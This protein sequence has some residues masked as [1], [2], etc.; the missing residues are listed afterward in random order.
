M[1]SNLRGEFGKLS[2]SISWERPDFSDAKVD[3]TI[4]AASV[5]TRDAERDGNLRG[6]DFFDVKKFPSLTFKSKRVAKAKAKGHLLL[7]GD[8][9]IH[10]VTKEVAFDV[11]GP[12]AEQKT[13][14]G[15]VAIAAE[16]KATINR[17][18]FGLTWNQALET[19]GV[20]VGDEVRIDIALEL[21]KKP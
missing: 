18:D 19:G 20:L 11:T 1:I 17:K 8:L 4:D 3:V 14:W 7:V 12:T 2:G 16:A 13:P 6:A 15:A 21:D 9:T 5:E 10:G